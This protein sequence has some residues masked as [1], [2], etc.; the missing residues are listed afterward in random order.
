MKKTL[1]N[2]QV[3][4]HLAVNPCKEL[5]MY[6]ESPLE[7]VENVVAWWGVRHQ[8]FSYYKHSFIGV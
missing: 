2:H 5:C 1:Q 8:I 7:D 3:R 4:D 6:L